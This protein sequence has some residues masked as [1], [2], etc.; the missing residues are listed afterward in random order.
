MHV[1]GDGVRRLPVAA[2]VVPQGA[3]RVADRRRCR[4]LDAR[5]ELL[6]RHR[7]FAS[8]RTAMLRNCRRLGELV[9]WPSFFEPW[10]CSAIGP[11]GG[12]P[13]SCALLIT[14]C[15]FSTTVRRSPRIVISNV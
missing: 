9:H 8:S 5:Q 10:C 3:Q 15:P 7:A 13:G 11:R 6:E 2:G 14:S 12:I 1:L 4:V